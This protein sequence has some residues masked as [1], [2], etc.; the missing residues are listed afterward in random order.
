MARVERERARERERERRRERER[1]RERE[2]GREGERVGFSVS[3]ILRR[4]SLSRY[5]YTLSMSHLV[6]GD[7]FKTSIFPLSQ[8]YTCPLSQLYT[9][10]YGMCNSSRKYL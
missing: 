8:L 9:V 2:R 6:I 4:T 5:N 3:I 7:T 10:C 1:E